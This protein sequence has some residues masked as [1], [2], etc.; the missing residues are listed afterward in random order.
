V[1]LYLN[2]DEQTQLENLGEKFKYAE[3]L[4]N[5]AMPG[6]RDTHFT[7]D[8]AD[9]FEWKDVCDSEKGF[10]PRATGSLRRKLQSFYSKIG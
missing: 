2:Q 4:W 6:N 5:L 10:F 9:A 7:V 1:D 8:R 3:L